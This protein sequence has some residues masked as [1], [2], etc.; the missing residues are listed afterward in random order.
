LALSTQQTR[1]IAEISPH[2]LSSGQAAATQDSREMEL[3]MLEPRDHFSTELTE[4]EVALFSSRSNEGEFS[5]LIVAEIV[6]EANHQIQSFSASNAVAH[7]SPHHGDMAAPRNMPRQSNVVGFDVGGHLGADLSSGQFSPTQ[8]SS[9]VD[10]GLTIPMASKDQDKDHS[11]SRKRTPLRSMA[12]NNG[13]QLSSSPVEPSPKKQ[14]LADDNVAAIPAISDD[15]IE[16]IEALPSRTATPAS[17]VN[18]RPEIVLQSKST[19]RVRSR[20]ESPDPLD[21]IPNQSAISFIPSNSRPQQPRSS[22]TESTSAGNERKSSRV[23]AATEKK[24]LEKEEKRRIRRER[25]AR[26]EEERKLKTPEPSSKSKRQ[27]TTDSLS[28]VARSTKQSKSKNTP[29]DEIPTPTSAPIIADV[30]AELATIR[31]VGARASIGSQEPEDA[32]SPSSVAIETVVLENEVDL[33]EHQGEESPVKSPAQVE[34]GPL[35]N[36]AQSP[37]KAQVSGSGF[38]GRSEPPLHLHDSRQRERVASTSST[39]DSPGP[40]GADGRP[41]RPQGIRWQTSKY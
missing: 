32:H 22:A 2:S 18:R 7:S 10:P 35:Q 30:H 5:P 31:P 34:V 36:I 15:E 19:S 20:I 6:D 27:K 40:A 17:R 14:R 25:K 28:T 12:V 23:Q 3:K 8:L 1:D 33:L 4:D 9:H 24:E 26:E 39:R 21:I 41:Q 16:V 13:F 29:S 11:C 38:A 37:V